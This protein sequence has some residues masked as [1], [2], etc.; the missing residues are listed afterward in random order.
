MGG[1]PVVEPGADGGYGSDM[2]AGVEG[3][4]PRP[5]FANRSWLGLKNSW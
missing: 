4:G 1:A 5:E 3:A 2:A